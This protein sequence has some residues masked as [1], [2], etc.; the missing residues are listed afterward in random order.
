MSAVGQTLKVL[1]HGVGLTLETASERAGLDLRH[2][3][4]VESGGMNITLATLV[5]LAD[6]LSVPPMQLLRTIDAGGRPI[7]NRPLSNR[8]NPEIDDTNPS[9]YGPSAASMADN[10]SPPTKPPTGASDIRAVIGRKVSSLRKE[11]GWTQSALA[12][13]AEC[14]LQHL[15]RIEAGRQNATVQVLARLAEAL[16]VSVAELVRLDP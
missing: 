5:K 8:S 13:R 15:Q 10:T 4:K 11:K 12:E 3:Q 7:A 9:A 1:R 2:W 14:A 6:A 16:G